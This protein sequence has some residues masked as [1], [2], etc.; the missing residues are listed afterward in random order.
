MELHDLHDL[1][2]AGH[3]EWCCF[4]E[5]DLRASDDLQYLNYLQAL[6]LVHLGE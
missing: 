4:Q 2:D 5:L 1:Q 6:F 3:D